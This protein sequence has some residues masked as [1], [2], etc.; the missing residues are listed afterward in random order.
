[1]RS[2]LAGRHELEELANTAEETGDDLLGLGGGRLYHSQR[3]IIIGIVE[4]PETGRS[5]GSKERN[6][7]SMILQEEGDR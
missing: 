6:Q 1:M 2:I 3:L 4:K 7:L 5:P